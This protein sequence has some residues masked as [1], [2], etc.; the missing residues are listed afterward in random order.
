MVSPSLQDQLAARYQE[1]DERSGLA[2][3][4]LVLM[5]EVGELAE[6]IRRGRNDDVRAELVDVA[7]MTLAMANV[8]G[9]DVEHGVRA[10]FL[11]R[12]DEAVRVS[13]DDVPE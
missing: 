7:F 4:A 1:G 2:F 9:A 10:K 6:A 13:W 3:L 12:P 5:E 11:S 8:A